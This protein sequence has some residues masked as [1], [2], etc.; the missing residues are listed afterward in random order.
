M[1]TFVNFLFF[2]FILFPVYQEKAFA[3][4]LLGDQLLM[5]HLSRSNLL[6]TH[7]RIMRPQEKERRLVT[8]L[9]VI[10][11][12][13]LS[14]HDTSLNEYLL[15]LSFLYQDLPDRLKKMEYL[16]LK[17]S[18]DLLGDTLAL[19]LQQ[20]ESLR[21]RMKKFN[22]YV[23]RPL[24]QQRQAIPVRNLSLEDALIV[25]EDYVLIDL[26]LLFSKDYLCAYDGLIKRCL[27]L[28]DQT[29]EKRILH[30]SFMR[31]IQEYFPGNQR[32]IHLDGLVKSST[33][34]L[35]L[36]ELLTKWAINDC[37]LFKRA[38]EVGAYEFLAGSLKIFHH[39]SHKISSIKE[40]EIQV[41]FIQSL[42][43]IAIHDDLIPF[44]FACSLYT[45]NIQSES[46]LVKNSRPKACFSAQAYLVL[47]GLFASYD[48]TLQATIPVNFLGTQS[49]FR[50]DAL[51]RFAHNQLITTGS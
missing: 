14:Y 6:S 16:L 5:E 44:Y 46:C 49:T 48:H 50:K 29:K 33:K 25:Q 15:Q 1:G 13:L 36:F 19:S 37:S 45:K 18:A 21:N 51:V 8:L 34:E 4:D 30:T 32:I 7:Q 12:M 26:M 22:N 20:Q 11:E 41:S 39:Y 24:S 10:H 31:L 27:S 2:M 28:F 43:S 42:L 38:I 40:Y 35:Y 9:T 47:M 3:G 17:R 23:I